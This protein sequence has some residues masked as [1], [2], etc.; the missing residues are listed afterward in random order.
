V[1]LADRQ[2]PHEQHHQRTLEQQILDALLRIEELL[3]AQASTDEGPYTGE[4]IQDVI[5][6]VKPTPTPFQKAVAK[7][8]TGARKVDRL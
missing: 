3:Q 6:N 5:V 2:R 1:S 8:P 7:K 4:D